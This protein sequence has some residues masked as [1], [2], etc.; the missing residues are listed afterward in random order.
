VTGNVIDPII[1]PHDLVNLHLS[2]LHP[3]YQSQ[4]R[5]IPLQCLNGALV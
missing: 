4:R 3:A 5:R 2:I 1:R